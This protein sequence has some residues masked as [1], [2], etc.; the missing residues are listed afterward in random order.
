MFILANFIAAVAYILGYLLWA[1]SWILVGRVIAD[2]INADPYNPIVRFLYNV[3]EPV[4]EPIRRR[5]PVHFGGFDLSPIVAWLIIM[6]LQMFLVRSLND[7]AYSLR[8]TL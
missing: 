5:L 1:Y 3:T 2:W 7:L 6:F 4:L 8:G